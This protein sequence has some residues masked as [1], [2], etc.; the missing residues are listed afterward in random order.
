M[1]GDEGF[2][3]RSRVTQVKDMDFIIAS[4][5]YVERKV[6]RKVKDKK[7]GKS[8]GRRLFMACMSLHLCIRVPL[9]PLSVGISHTKRGYFYH[10]G[11]VSG[12]DDLQ[13]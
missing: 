11:P 8:N 1:N 3:Q 13:I 5:E 6:L 9:R 12:P 4:I 2:T 7:E 10:K